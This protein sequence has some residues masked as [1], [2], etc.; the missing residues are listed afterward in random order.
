LQKKY[1]NKY[2]IIVDMD[3]RYQVYK[4]FTSYKQEKDERNMDEICIHKD[5]EFQLQVQQQFLKDYITVNKDWKSLL[6]YH[7]IGSGKTCTAITVAEAYFES[8]ADKSSKPK[9]TIILP[10][11]LRTNFLDELI[12]P[13]GFQKYISNT[14]FALFKAATTPATV[15]A[16]IR[17]GFMKK[18]EEKYK[19]LSYEGFTKLMMQGKANIID[20]IQNWT[21]NNILII[22]EVHNV[23]STKYD[24]KVYEKIYQSGVL[25]SGAKGINAILMNL[26]VRY[27]DPSCRMVYLTA[28]PIFNHINQLRELVKIMTPEVELPMANSLSQLI[29]LLRGKVSYFPGIGKNAYPAVEYIHH[30]IMITKSQ[31][32]VI[33]AI[34]LKEEKEEKEDEDAVLQEDA[35]LIKQRLNELCMVEKEQLDMK[36]I[37][38]FA[39]KIKLL[40]ENLQKNIG[41]QVVFTNFIN[42]SIEPIEKILRMQG[43]YNIFDVI[44]H[45]NNAAEWEKY[46][47]KVYAVWSGSTKDDKKHLIKSMMNNKNNLF[48]EYIKVVLGSPSI[49]EG[50]SFLHVQ[51]MHLMDPVWN[52][53]SKNQVE[54]RVIR[55]CS[56]VDINEEL[57]R[58]L[59]RKVNIHYYKIV[60]NPAGLVEKTADEKIYDEIIPEKYKSV[61]VGEKALKKVAIDYHLFKNMY[62]NPR[63]KSPTSPKSGKSYISYSDNEDIKEKH[64]K[65]GHKC[66]KNRRPV[67]GNCPPKWEVKKNKYGEPCCYRGKKAVNHEDKKI[68]KC[69]VARRP[70]NGMCA[71]GYELRTNRYGV[72]CCYK[73]RRE[74]LMPRGSASS[75]SSMTLSRM[76]SPRSTRSAKSAPILSRSTSNRTRSNRSV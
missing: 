1:A 57:H 43:W 17:L 37:A 14:D 11:R 9:A 34:N 63:S 62:K 36:N 64:K 10:A 21:K 52:M 18:I 16:R 61:Q 50:I 30:N 55:Y 35:F 69:P 46:K 24:L 51:D 13:C 41:K 25:P 53:S 39:P 28:T 27:C 5:G 59:K 23:F 70:V 2:D 71:D 22:D 68:P 6:F 38:E 42:R 44:Q 12:S 76:Q 4:S 8:L 26:I 54:G 58:P 19:I 15:K 40:V 49:K 67:N 74:T 32:E 48:G 56:H 33:H 7:E 60:H 3:S 47:Y 75:F 66:P 65:E 20:F 72:P 31:D 45:I 73:I 29:E